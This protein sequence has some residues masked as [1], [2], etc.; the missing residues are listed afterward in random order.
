MADPAQQAI[1]DEA[2]CRMRRWRDSGDGALSY[3]AGSV[4]FAEDVKALLAEVERCRQTHTCD[5]G[6]GRRPCP[7]PD[8]HRLCDHPLDWPEDAAALGLLDDE[9]AG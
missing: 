8:G 1:L 2:L 3:A 7:G 5:C 9:P 6:T 4:T